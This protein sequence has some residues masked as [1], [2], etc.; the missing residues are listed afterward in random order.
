MG[1]PPP[2]AGGAAE[3]G[4]LRL[5]KGEVA[6]RP[7]RDGD[8]EAL[9]EAA[10]NPKVSQYFT[11]GHFPRPYRQADAEAWLK[12]AAA[13]S[14]TLNFAIEWRGKFVGTIGL[15]RCGPDEPDAAVLGYWLGEPYWGRG[16]ASRAVALLLPY[17]FE[18]VCRRLL[19]T[20]H[21]DNFPSR[22]ILEKAG[23]TL[24]RVE[25]RPGQNGGP[26]REVLF[27]AL[28]SDGFYGR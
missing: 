14:P 1:P 4:G 26:D 24:W 25:R 7:Y 5:G 6:L 18:R 13:E 17:A 19:A 3:E 28:D 23:F 27:F 10:D 11:A 2:A 22:R 21:P 20:V 16:L 9:V 12:R 15:A 8:V